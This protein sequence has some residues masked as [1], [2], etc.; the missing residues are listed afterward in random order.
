MAKIQ[1]TPLNA[2]HHEAGARMVE[3]HGWE[4][5]VQYDGVMAEHRRTRAEVSLFDVSHM[6]E[7]YFEGKEALSN[8]QRITT[9][10]VSKLAIGQV[11]YSTM[12]H[13]NGTIVDDLTV[14]RLGEDKYQACINASNIDKDFAWIQ[15]NIEGE[16]ICENQ[17]DETGQIAIQGPKAQTLLQALTDYD[18][19][20]IKYYWCATGKVAGCDTLIARMGYTGEDGF[21]VFC[22]K[23]ETATIW[24][25]LMEKGADLGVAPAG[26]GA[27]DTLRLEVCYPLYGNDLDDQHNALE[28]GLGWVVKMAK[29]D[30]IGKEALLKVKEE[31]LK[32]RLISFKLDCKGVPRQDYKIFDETGEKELGIVTSGTSSPILGEGIGMGYVAFDSKKPG[33]KI[34]IQVRKRLLPATIVKSPFVVVEK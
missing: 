31:G 5:P 12:L 1:K 11:Q 28:S 21:E 6:G 23:E 14:Y 22:K 8:L 19:D 26:L 2:I 29:G 18:L 32:R 17:S 16:L 25:Q 33:T 15:K 9:N 13:E 34:T 10:D 3:F 4:M 27:R 7:V 30:F 24:N 20:S